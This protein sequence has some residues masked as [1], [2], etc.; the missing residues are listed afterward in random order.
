MSERAHS[1]RSERKSIEELRAGL[2]NKLYWA[3]VAAAV[4]AGF[5]SAY[6]YAMA[7][8]TIS[9]LPPVA[10]YLATLLVLLLKGYK[11]IVGRRK[12]SYHGIGTY[13]V[14]WFATY[15]LFLSILVYL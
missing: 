8:Y 12:A 3:R 10:I 1:S 15:V 11:D 4:A 6:L 5:L 13:I 7:L 9:L 14:G 2:L